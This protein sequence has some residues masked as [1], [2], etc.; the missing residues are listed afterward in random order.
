MSE[1]IEDENNQ[2][3]VDLN[4]KLMKSNIDNITNINK[5][6]FSAMSLMQNQINETQKL[7]LITS[8]FINSNS[9]VSTKNK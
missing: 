9:L 1:I 8:M 4:S 6:F 3:S 2:K 7:K 5:P